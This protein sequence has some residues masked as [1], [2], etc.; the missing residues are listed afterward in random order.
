MSFFVIF[1]QNFHV[2]IFFHLFLW[3]KYR[4]LMLLSECIPTSSSYHMASSCLN[5]V[6]P[7]EDPDQRHRQ[8]SSWSKISL[9]LNCY[10]KTKKDK[11]MRQS[12]WYCY[13][14]WFQV[15]KISELSV[16]DFCLGNL[17][18]ARQTIKKTIFYFLP[19]ATILVWYLLYTYHGVIPMMFI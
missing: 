11:K 3:K 16:K 5:C 15:L 12:V 17:I 2:N 7:K 4:C 9:S 19:I 13:M 6:L 18:K 14:Y 8:H 1:R 10:K